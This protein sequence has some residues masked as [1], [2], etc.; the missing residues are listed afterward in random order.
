MAAATSSI[1]TCPLGGPNKSITTNHAPSNFF[2]TRA[3]G[4]R[5]SLPP[6]WS[7]VACR[8]AVGRHWALYAAARRAVTRSCR[9]STWGAGGRASLL[10]GGS[11]TLGGD[12]GN[13]GA[14]RVRSDLIDWEDDD[15]LPRVR[16]PH[17]P[18]SH[19]VRWPPSPPSTG[20]TRAC[21]QVHQVNIAK[22]KDRLYFWLRSFSC[23]HNNIFWSYIHL[24]WSFPPASHY[25]S[26][27]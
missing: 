14:G 1:L 21:A 9:S 19:G 27:G 20:D 3:L 13:D 12:L 11:P 25:I 4:A 15:P 23:S 18:A 10:A 17:R 6:H 24:W 26:R 16:G 8:P 2:I 7:T 22:F 5:C